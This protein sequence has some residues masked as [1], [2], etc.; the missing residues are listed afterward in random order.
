MAG[1]LIVFAGRRWIIREVDEPSRIITVD[2]HKGGTPPAFEDSTPE[3]VDD[4]L[5]A[6]MLA[7]Y[8]GDDQPGWIDATMGLLLKEGRTSF[9]RLGLDRQRAFR[10]GDDVHLF[11][12]RG[13]KSNG[14]LAILLGGAGFSCW[15]HDVGVV[16]SRPNLQKLAEKLTELQLSGVPDLDK[17]ASDVSAISVGKFDGLIAPTVLRGFWALG[18]QGAVNE[19]QSTVAPLQP[20]CEGNYIENDA[21]PHLAIKKEA[22]PS[23]DASDDDNR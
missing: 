11:T 13:T 8:L 16:V 21:N 18:V 5:A 19:I 17:V 22:A 14:L 3:P 7:V 12:W 15:A 20:I 23:D 1:N 10:S 6:E 4:R 2:P 9:R